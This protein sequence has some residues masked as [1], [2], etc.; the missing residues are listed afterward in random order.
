[1]RRLLTLFALILSGLPL[2]APAP[3]HAE[4]IASADSPGKV[5]S[6]AVDLDNDGR[7]RYRLTRF[8]HEVIAPSLLGFLLRD[9]GRIERNLERVGAATTS[10]DTDWE[11]PWGEQRRIRNHY[12]ELV[13][14]L[15]EKIAPARVMTVRFRIYD[16]GLGFRYEFP[17]QS[18]S[19]DFI[20]DD[21]LTE[22]RIA[23]PATAWWIP[24]GESN[25]YEYLYRRTPVEEVSMAHTPM[26]LRT[27]NGLHLSFHEAALVDYSAMWLRRVEG[28]GF[29]AE[30]SP[31]SQ[32][33]K[34][35]RTAPFH[36]PW[37]TI[38]VSD[39]AGGLVDSR[40]ILN[41]NEPNKLGDVSYF[42]PHKYIGI[43][44]AMHL[45]DW[46]W[47][48]G[49]KH[50]ATT[51][52]ARRYIDFA[53]ENGFR[54]VLI[55][56][57]NVGWDGTWFGNGGDFDFDRPYPDFDMDAV[58]DYAR[59]KGVHII[60]HH[61]TGGNIC[62]YEPQ[63]EAALDYYKRHGVDAVKTGYV[64]DAGGIIDCD[65][66]G[67]AVTEW[68]DGQ[69]MVNHHLK[70]VT[71]AAKRGIA[72][73]PHE[74][75]KDTGL[76]RTYPNWVAREGARGMEYAAWGVPNNSPEHDVNLVFTRLLAGPMDYTPG[77]LSLKGRGG[78]PIE[79]TLAR[80][81][82]YYVT[83]YSP[84]Q[85]M[86][87]LPENVGPYRDAMQ[88]I[89]DVPTDWEDSI[90]LNGEVGDYVTIARRDRNSRDWYLGAITDEEGR[91]LDVPLSFLEPGVTYTA[92][93][94][95]DGPDA[96]YDGNQHDI[97]IEERQ[98]TGA[99][100]MTLR[101]ARGGGAAIRFVAP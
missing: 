100:R 64:A 54:G 56:G 7:A 79:S 90:T 48:S 13:V 61:E 84:I 82:A 47:A 52:H 15:R 17:P 49:D 35:R 12:T 77:V 62:V 68:H 29:R 19:N 22:F 36:T 21:E 16:D 24:A 94:Y 34:V 76:R 31:A 75:V 70:V 71:E 98:V 50:G 81:L 60:G 66:K 101:L 32:G 28:R 30:L 95:R 4:T 43:W 85:M 63:L 27:E 67:K 23:D 39:T 40:L 92:Q 59:R 5:L 97:V 2:A 26:T 8:G 89:L 57:W 37:R 46:S 18:G 41:L 91:L 69:R 10:V 65:A 45:E 93:I 44:W 86:A 88:F 1:M 11:Q 6:V 73:N 42:T 78:R 33:W 96:A 74:P 9:Q 87:D 80:Q 99:D 72:V 20:I 14:T 53:A 38:Q 55:E 51:E 58:A 83:L 25:R 3:A